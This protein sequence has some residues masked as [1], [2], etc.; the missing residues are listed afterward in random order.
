MIVKNSDSHPLEKLRDILKQQKGVLFTSDLRQYGIPRTY[1]SLLEKQ[2]EIKRVA[3]G[4]YSSPGSMIDEMAA[5]QAKYQ[6]AVFSH[7]TAAFLLDLSDRTPLYYTVTVQS[8]YNATALKKGGTRV[9]YTSRTVF[10]LGLITLKSSHGNDV[11]AFNMERTICDLL[12][13]RNQI[14]IQQINT[15]L[16]RYA[17]NKNRNIDLLYQYAKQFRVQ[18]IVREYLEILL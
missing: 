6:Q 8:G 15:S 13:N 3:W 5:L 17:N 16:K 4:V 18:K 7:E 1:L 11:R 14:D 9:F 12:R 10:S 2:G